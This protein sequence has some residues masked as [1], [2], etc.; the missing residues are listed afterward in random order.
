MEKRAKGSLKYPK[1]QELLGLSKGATGKRAPCCPAGDRGQAAPRRTS[2]HATYTWRRGGRLKELRIRHLARKFLYL[3]MKRTFGTVLPSSARCHYERRTLQKTFRE[4]KEEWWVSCRE[5]KL[6][7][8]A[9]CHYRYFLCNTVFLAWRSHVLQQQEKKTISSIAEAHVRAVKGRW[10]WCRWLSC[11]E[12][13]RM[14]RGMLLEALQFRE[15]SSLRLSWRLWRKRWSQNQ[16]DCERDRQALQH[17]AHSLQRW[18]WLQ[19]KALCVGIQRGRKEE[20]RAV[21]HGQRRE[22]R[23]CL[24]SWHVCVQLQRVKKHHCELALQH[25]RICM[26]LRGFSVWRLTWERSQRWHQHRE[27]LLQL[28]ARVALRRIFARWKCYLVLC[29]EAAGRDARAEEHCKH[30]LLSWPARRAVRTQLRP[31]RAALGF[32]LPAPPPLQHRGF[33]AFQRNATSAS[34]KRSQRSLAQQQRRIT[35]L[36]RFWNGWKSRLEQEE[37]KQHPSLALAAHS[38]YR[39]GLLRKCL[40]TW[41]CCASLARHGKLQCARAEQ[42]HM[43]AT[44]LA[45]FRAWRLFSDHQRRCRVMARMAESFQRATWTRRTFG[46][47][48]RRGREQRENRLAEEK[49]VVHSEQQLLSQFWCLW[50]RRTAARLA[51]QE[52]LSL[53]TEHHSHQVLQKMLQ[54]WSK[55]VQS[56]KAE[57]MEEAE[58]SR[59]HSAQLLRCSWGKWQ[60]YL[61]HRSKK[62][63]KLVRAEVHYQQILLRRAMSGWKGYQENVRHLLL[64]VAA[65]EQEQH[66]AL[67]RRALRTWRGNAANSRREAQQ[68]ALATQHHARA[69]L[70]KVVLKWRDAASLCARCRQQEAAAV[71]D[72]KQHLHAVRRRAVFLR[73]RAASLRARQERDLLAAAAEHHG[74]RLLREA[75]ARWRQDHLRGARRTLARRQQERREAVRALCHWSQSLQARVF[76]AWL[77]FVREQRRK[78]RRL[79]G[80]V[81]AYRGDLLRDGVARILRY[82]SG[83]A[84]FRGQLRAQ[85]QLKVACRH[86]QAVA[87]CAQ[88]WKWRALGQRSLP[89]RPAGAPCTE[90]AVFQG[91]TL[92]AGSS[93][94]GDPGD[95]AGLAGVPQ[96]ARR[97]HPPPLWAAGDA[98]LTELCTARR[99]RLQPRRLGVLPLFLE[100]TG[101]PGAAGEGLEGQPGLL[102]QATPSKL[103]APAVAMLPAAP[104]GPSAPALPQ[105]TMPPRLG[106]GQCSPACGGPGLWPL[107][108]LRPEVVAPLGP[109]SGQLSARPLAA[110][111]RGAGEAASSRAALLTPEDAAGSASPPPRVPG[112]EGR[113]QPTGRF[114][115]EAAGHRQLEA[116]LQCI[117]HRMQCFRHKQQ[118]LRSCQRR[119]RI[120]CKWLEMRTGAE[121]PAE[122][123]QVREQLDRLKVQTDSLIHVLGEERR[124]M[125]SFISRVQDIRAALD[126]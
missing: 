12:L 39:M 20:A 108:S 124:Q 103:P 41:L 113:G 119:E 111:R 75:L 114:P 49:A 25:R 89:S 93:P 76:D 32:R 84:Q 106:P 83:M 99:A 4:W 102:P 101:T 63:E 7:I 98:V 105:S 61:R 31:A 43:R 71:E 112:T 1:T 36:H 37:E 64:Q 26:L 120:L 8:R 109:P 46:R 66:R 91:A 9:D 27:R 52:G 59:F 68:A 60:Q 47:W 125:R 53:A 82:M 88:R 123:Q 58:A 22:L 70:L 96:P 95:H 56:I 42:H 94:G 44:L 78:K 110:A 65:K 6:T 104:S 18:A 117:G 57:R 87:R 77:W 5:W 14:K 62:W 126:I 85:H 13:R 81:A 72:A 122:E 33:R 29:A 118:E 67:L 45:A 121:E 92:P 16:A 15:Q 74:W 35:L 50:H 115:G 54:L 69:F 107:A 51:E 34:A 40:R 24:R 100:G 97:D 55:N 10:A 38:H 21:R 73:W 90:Q 2:C 11:M 3:W 23:K 28:A 48:Q 80:A 17:W 86:Q 79:E 30:R 19:W 116:E